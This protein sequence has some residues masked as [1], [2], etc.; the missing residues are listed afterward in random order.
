MTVSCAMPISVRNSHLPASRPPMPTRVDSTRSSVP[1]STSSSSAPLG[2]RRSR[3]AGTSRRCPRRRTRSRLSRLPWRITSTV[4]MAMPKMPRR[5]ACGAAA[6]WRRRLACSWASQ[7]IHRGA[8]LRRQ[9]AGVALELRDATLHQDVRRRRH[10]HF[11]QQAVDHLR[12]DL[13]PRRRPAAAR[14]APAAWPKRRCARR[15]PARQN[16]RDRHVPVAH[17]LFRGGAIQRRALA[18]RVDRRPHAQTL[19]RRGVRRSDRRLSS[20]SSSSTTA[21]RI[22]ARGALPWLPNTVAKIEKKIDRQQEGQRLRDAIALEVGPADPQAASQSFPQLPSGQ[23]DEHRLQARAADLDVLDLAPLRSHRG[24]Q[25]R[26]L[27]RDI[28]HARPQHAAGPRRHVSSPAAAA[29]S[30]ASVAASRSDGVRPSDR[31]ARRASPRR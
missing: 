24:E 19:L 30:G 15:Q 10:R 25:R 29:A 11:L 23:M 9:R 7:R 2:T 3:T 4:S 14:A 20:L 5:A 6:A 13:D 28:G 26:K 12:R 21:T 1:E 16:D 8:L 18:V 31:R 27:T 17:Q 22:R